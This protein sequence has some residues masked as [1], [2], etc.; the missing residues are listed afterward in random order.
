MLRNSWDAWLRKAGLYLD[1]RMSSPV[2][3][4]SVKVQTLHLDKGSRRGIPGA[5][6]V[7]HIATGHGGFGT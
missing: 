3:Q 6:A 7:P 1:W 2:F 4:A 5:Q